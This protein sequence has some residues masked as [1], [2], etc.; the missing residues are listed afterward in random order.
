ME[1]KAQADPV[2]DEL[3][4]GNDLHVRVRGPL[5]C[6]II[7]AVNER[8]QRAMCAL[9][10][11]AVALGLLIFNSACDCPSIQSA[12][13][14]I[15]GAQTAVI[16]AQTAVTSA[17][18][19]VSA[20]QTL[21]PGAQTALPGLQATVQAGA[22]SV[23]GV[24][25][26]PQAVATQLQPLLAGA[27]IDVKTTPAGASNDAVTQVTITGTDTRG[28]FGQLD[29]STR[30][31]TAQRRL[32]DRWPV[33]PERDHFAVGGRQQRQRTAERHRRRPARRRLIQ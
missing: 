19:A 20:V 16:G 13:T 5:Q 29:P 1:A 6:A 28:T 18:T 7:R 8:R 14:A 9:G 10:T 23:A 33:L 12:Q 4:V 22:T 2:L 11:S 32:A 26:D 15:T 24:L 17:Q 21:V 30:Q 25:G 31:A 27:S 3:L